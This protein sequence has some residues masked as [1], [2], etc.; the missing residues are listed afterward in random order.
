MNKYTIKQINKKPDLHG[1]KF[2]TVEDATTAMISILKAAVKFGADEDK[3]TEF[4]G[5]GS[6]KV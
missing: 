1:K 5:L 3:L 4:L 6:N 2:V